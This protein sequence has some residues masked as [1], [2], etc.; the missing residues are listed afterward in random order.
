MSHHVDLRLDNGWAT[1]VAPVP[2]AKLRDRL[3]DRFD[4]DGDDATWEVGAALTD[5]FLEGARHASVEIAAQLVRQGVQVVVER[6]I[7]GDE[8]AEP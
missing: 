1:D 5:A 7:V 4:L 3:L 2:I 6:P 8:G